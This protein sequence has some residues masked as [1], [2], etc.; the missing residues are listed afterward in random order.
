M[1]S[2][3][4]V[5]APSPS[6]STYEHRVEVGLVA[7][8]ALAVGAV[9][10]FG[11]EDHAPREPARRT[12]PGP[13]LAVAPPG[14]LRRPCPDD[15]SVVEGLFCPEARE[16]CERWLEDPAST[17][18][19]RCARFAPSVCTSERVPLRFCIDREE[20]ARPGD[21]RPVGDVSFTDGERLCGERGRRL[22]TER[23]WTFACEGEDL[24]PYPYGFE[25]DGTACNFERTDLLDEHGEMRDLRAPTSAFPACY[26]PFGVHDMVGN[27]DE[28]VRLDRPHYSEKNGNRRMWSGLKGGWWGPLR[29]RCRP[30]TVDHDE[31]FHELQTGFRC[32]ADAP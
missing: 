15:M 6:P 14:E 7:L 4:D 32:C 28:W 19:A 3:V 16:S 24:R 13:A 29:N 25:R 23:E 12:T 22:C 21:D 17:P 20:Y 11:F 5:R 18:F 26:S 10:Y 9:S 1:T 31:R 8:L 2:R 27:V 30:V